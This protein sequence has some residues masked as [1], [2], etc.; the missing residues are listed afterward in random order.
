MLPW[1]EGEDELDSVY[2]DLQALEQDE[3]FG[4]QADQPQGSK[5]D[6]VNELLPQLRRSDRRGKSR[7]KKGKQPSKPELQNKKANTPP[8]LPP[9]TSPDPLDEIVR[10][11]A[12][13]PQP[14]TNS[15]SDRITKAFTYTRS[16]LKRHRNDAESTT[17]SDEEGSESR[18]KH[19]VRKRRRE[20]RKVS[21]VDGV[22]RKWE[23]M[24]AGKSDG[25]LPKYPY[26]YDEEGKGRLSGALVWGIIGM[27]S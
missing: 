24:T 7:G 22:W 21:I 5:P 17:S 19:L 27:I 11:L 1:E 9:I 4:V 12:L 16:D 8:L 14:Q 2:G 25:L 26:A 10:T 18:G 13:C 3:P 20:T 6:G 23:E 15:S